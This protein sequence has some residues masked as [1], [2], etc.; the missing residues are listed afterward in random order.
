MLLFDQWKYFIRCD[1][2]IETEIQ[3]IIWKT[4]K[5]EFF[6]D[7]ILTVPYSFVL[8]SKSVK[9]KNARKCILVMN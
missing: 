2:T 7:L 3:F 9:Q 1:E 8:H 4:S 5:T 6:I